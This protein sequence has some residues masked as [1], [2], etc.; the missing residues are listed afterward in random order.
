MTLDEHVE[1]FDCGRFCEGC[2]ELLIVELG[3][4]ACNFNRRRFCQ[5]DCASLTR[6]VP[7]AEHKERLLLAQH[8]WNEYA[9]YL[10]GATLANPMWEPAA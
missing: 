5:I 6:T 7:E 2:T 9:S 8:R 10:R 3:E 4:R 1:S